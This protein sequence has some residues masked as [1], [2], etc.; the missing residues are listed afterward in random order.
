MRAFA[1]GPSPS[2]KLALHGLN[3]MIHEPQLQCRHPACPALCVRVLRMIDSDPSLHLT[4]IDVIVSNAVDAAWQV[5][6]MARRQ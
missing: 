4:R 2:P 5:A 3:T 6:H 1:A